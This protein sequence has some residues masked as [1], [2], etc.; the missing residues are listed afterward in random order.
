MTYE[1][2]R[3]RHNAVVNRSALKMAMTF[4]RLS[5]QELADRAKV[6]KG[7][8]GGLLTKRNTCNPETAAKIAKALKCDTSDL[9]TLSSVSTVGSTPRRWAA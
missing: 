1:E 9:F 6:S 8:I 4:H 3:R 2:T 5:N 7:T